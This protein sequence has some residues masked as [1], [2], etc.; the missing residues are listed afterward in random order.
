ME[1]SST[2]TNK[3]EEKKS[4]FLYD[5]KYWLLF[6]AGLIVII[7]IIGYI[8]FFN[9]LTEQQQ[10]NQEMKEDFEQLAELTDEQG[11]TWEDIKHLIKR[12]KKFN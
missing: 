12:Y 4:Y 5:Y 9:K 10:V 11:V 7:V 8:F 2:K 6:A 3:D 1:D